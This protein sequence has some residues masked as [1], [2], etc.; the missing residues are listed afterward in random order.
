MSKNEFREGD[1]V[2]STSHGMEGYMGI[3]I[4]PHYYRHL[5]NPRVQVLHMIYWFLG[6][7]S[8]AFLV[9]EPLLKRLR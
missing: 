8:R 9:P 2:A 7:H 6:E 3:V 1:L 5:Q 4:R